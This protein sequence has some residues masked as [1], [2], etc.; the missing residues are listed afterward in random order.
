MIH[1]NL[2]RLYKAITKY[3]T[4][5]IIMPLMSYG[6]LS[7]LLSF[8]YPNGIKDE[9]AI[10]TIMR[11][12][13]K[14]IECLNEHNYFHR[15]IKASNIL[16]ASNGSCRLGDFGVSTVIKKGGG[17]D[18]YVGSLCWMAPEIAQGA[19][20]NFKVDIWSLGITAIEIANGKPPFLGLT[21]F[22]YIKTV[23]NDAEPQLVDGK[24]VWSQEFK[25]FVKS[26][27]VKDPKKR[28]CATE[29]LTMN[30]KFFEK[31]KDNN[32]ILKNLLV[33]I[34]TL[35]ERVSNYYLIISFQKQVHMERAIRRI[36]HQKRIK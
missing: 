8:K 2:I 33:G 32:Y 30:K 27:L 14:A 26:C 31:A 3:N 18:S 9:V 12:C 10:A 36:K 29:I 24:H 15:D 11:N 23:V 19:E 5:Y 21:P 22:E 28:P 13:L 20:Y 34:P 35:Q 17:N 6:D 1:E 16:L 4:I 25:D 7:F